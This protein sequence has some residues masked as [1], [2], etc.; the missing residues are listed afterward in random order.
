MTD[1]GQKLTGLGKDIKAQL[2]MNETPRFKTL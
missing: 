2:D 1:A